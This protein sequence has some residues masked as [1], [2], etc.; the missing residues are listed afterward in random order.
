MSKN[1]KT[2]RAEPGRPPG[3]CAE[4]KETLLRLARQTLND[5]LGEGKLPQ[6][7]TDLEGLLQPHATFST[8]RRRDSGE[9]RGCRGERLALR[10]LVESVANM[11]V[12]A[13]TDDQR[14][15]PVRIDEVPDLRIEISVLTP[16]KPMQPEEV[17]VGRHGLM[18]T[19]GH[20]SGLLLPQVP[21]TYGWD[22]EEFLRG[23]C[24]KAGLSENAWEAGDVQL[25]GFETEVWGEE[26]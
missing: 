20:N 14:F 13:A 1:H 22:R 15:P 11:V 25:Y 3:L 17:V 5:Y 18:I 10:P 8:L 4:D 9:L 23:L 2:A 19:K 6:S 7:Q 21:R 12:A 26:D 24:R 16:M